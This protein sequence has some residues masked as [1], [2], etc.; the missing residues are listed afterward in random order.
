MPT[1]IAPAPPPGGLEAAMVAALLAALPFRPWAMLRAPGL[2]TPWLA[3]LVVLPLLWRTHHLLPPTLPLQL[4]GAALLVLMVGWPLAVWTLA[5]VAVLTALLAGVPPLSELASAAWS[6]VLPATL[7]LGFGLAVRRGMP[8]GPFVYIL[9]RSFFATA[10][11]TV[12]AGA[13]RTL[14][15]PLPEGTSLGSLLLA[16][17][18]IGS[19]EAVLTGMVTAI[20]VAF[21]PQGLATW[22]DARYLPQDD[23]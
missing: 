9:G 16:H 4:S 1:P 18:L 19:G 15:Q 7:A 23:G 22:S 3:S 20:L 2:R 6:G 11:A 13:L 14:W 21:R 10:C 12:A 17:L 5:A 8:H